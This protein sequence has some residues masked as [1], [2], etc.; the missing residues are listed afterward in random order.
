K[1]PAIRRPERITLDGCTR[2]GADLPVLTR[3]SIQQ[4]QMVAAQA[5]RPERQPRA[6]RRRPRDIFESAFESQPLRLARLQIQLP[7]IPRAA[8]CAVSDPL[9]CRIVA[10]LQV[11]AT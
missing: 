4:P 9:S 2:R 10:A 7:D 5:V 8:D 3:P 6:I 11:V 1:I